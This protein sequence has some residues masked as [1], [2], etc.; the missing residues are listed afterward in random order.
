MD[1][2]VDGVC[3]GCEEA[4]RDFA[5]GD[6]AGDIDEGDAVVAAWDDGGGVEA[7]GWGEVDGEFGG[8]AAGEEGEEDEGE[9]CRDCES[10]Y[11]LHTSTVGHGVLWV[12][13][14]TE[15]GCAMIPHD[16]RHTPVLLD[17]VL[18]QLDPQAGMVVVDVTAGRGG[19]AAE[20]GARLGGRGTLVIGDMDEGNLEAAAAHCRGHVGDG[21]EVVAIHTNFAG[22]PRELAK[23][24]LRGDRVL[25][26]LGFSSSQMDDGGRG[27][28]IRNDGP[29]DMRFDRGRGVSAATLVNTMSE[30]ELGEL[31]RDYGEERSWQAVARKVVAA[32]AEGPIETTAE[33][34]AIV[35]SAVRTPHKSHRNAGPSRS[36][37]PTGGG[38]RRREASTIDPATKTFQALR[39]AVNDELANL[40][41]LLE[42]VSRSA[43]GT[44]VNSGAGGWLAAGARV[45][46]ITFHS[47]EDRPVKQAFADMV[48]RGLGR[49]VSG[50]PAVAGVEEV[51][52]NPRSRSAKLRTIELTDPTPS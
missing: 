3:G 42:A 13:G 45:G 23:R 36:S 30:E 35:R 52:M 29:L 4:G 17:A 16:P 47:L 34:A 12:V 1:E 15:E 18:E 50:K 22:M 32:R 24:G 6:E 20:L 38:G 37:G 10:A 9:E 7:L 51:S 19:H 41:A 39:I 43:F 25:A 14:G 21:V 26:D 40:Q 44:R 11:L 48:S 27:M 46:V 31:I 8:E 33:L 2:A 28:S 49:T 5:L